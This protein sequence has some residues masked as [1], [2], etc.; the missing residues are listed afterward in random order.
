MMRSVI[1][2]AALLA[3]PPARADMPF[4]I[5]FDYGE[6]IPTKRQTCS[7]YFHGFAPLGWTKTKRRSFRN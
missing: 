1:L 3:L 7:D 5:D 4:N 2:A 6:L